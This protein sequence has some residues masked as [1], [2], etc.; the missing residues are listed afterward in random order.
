MTLPV[1]AVCVRNPDRS[2]VRINR[3]D[4]APTPAGFAEIVGDYF[5]VPHG[6]WILVLLDSTLFL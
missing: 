4:A 3:S 1:V 2:P 5:P 6:G